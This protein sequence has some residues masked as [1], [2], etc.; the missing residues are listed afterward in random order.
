VLSNIEV[1][2]ALAALRDGTL[3]PGLSPVVPGLS[4]S[5]PQTP[6]I[7]AATTLYRGGAPLFGEVQATFNLLDQSAGPALAAAHRAGMMVV[8]KEVSI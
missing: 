5:H 6:A 2:D 4:V 3:L 7:E 1:L 8:V